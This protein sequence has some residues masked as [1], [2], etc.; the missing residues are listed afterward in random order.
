MTASTISAIFFDLG[1]TLGTPVL[2]PPPSRLVRF[3]VF[4]FVP[5]I[6]D[7]LKRRKFRLGVISNT[8]DD[9][10][11]S[12]NGVLER[13]GLLGSFDPPL[14]IYSKDV[15]LTKSS[16]EI[17]RLAAERAG[18]AGTPRN[19]LFVGEDAKERA[20]A[21]DAGWT[22]APHP[23]LVS[24]AL[25]GQ[26]LRYIRA[27]VP[28]EHIG[29]NW[30]EA[31]RALPL[32]PLH[33]TGPQG[34]TV[35]AITSLRIVARLMNM[36]FDLELL[37]SHDAPLRTDLYILRDDAAAGS[38]FL[39][40]EG[41]STRFFTKADDAR[42][43]LRSG[44]E[45]LVVALPA[46]RSLEE[47]HFDRAYHGHTL[48]L[49]PDPSLLDPL[50]G[51][52]PQRAPAWLRSPPARFAG[53]ELSAEEEAALAQ[54]SGPV[55]LDRAE[56]YG[57]KRPL[58]A[59]ST[60]AIASRHI[61][62][63]D[64]K[65]ATVAVAEEFQRIGQGKL[66]VSLHQFTQA[67]RQLQNVEA[68]L[69]GGSP[70]L[71]LVTAHLDSTAAFSNP[72][73]ATHD[74]APGIDDDASGMAAVLSIAEMF[75]GLSSS[76]PPARTI[77]FVL[78]NAEE[79]GLV[80]SKAYA[81]QQRLM[82]APIVAVFQ[83][84]M[85]GYNKELPRTWEIHAGFSSSGDVEQRSRKLAELLGQLSSRVA[86]RLDAPQ[87]YTSASLEGDPAEG[88]SDHASFQAVGY[89]ACVASEDFFVGPRSDSPAPEA[90]PNY[91]MKEDAFIDGDF[92]ADIARVL[93]AGAW[94]TAKSSVAPHAGVQ[95]LSARG[96]LPMSR[97][98]D[99]RRTDAKLFGKTL[100]KGSG[101]TDV[102]A[103]RAETA[104]RTNAIT[105]AP[106]TVRATSDGGAPDASLVGRALTF[107]QQHRSAMGFDAATPADFVPDPTIQRTSAGAAA[108][109][110]QQSYRG[111]TVFQMAR[112]V[113][114]APSGEPVEAVGD[115]VAMQIDIDTEPKLDVLQAVVKAAEHL[116]STAG[117][118]Q[119]DRFGGTYKTP[120]VNVQGFKPSIVAGFPLPSRATV[121]T[122][123]PFEN[124]IPAYLLVF[125]HP[126]GPRLGW[127]VTLTLPNYEDQ[128][129]VI[130][131]ADR[132]QGEVLYSKSTMTGALARGSVY[133]QNPAD[134]PRRMI[135]FPRPISDYPVMP[136]SPLVGFPSDWIAQ[137]EAMG[138]STRAT[139]GSSTTT[140]KGTMNGGV[141]EFNPT[142][143]T[144][145]DQKILNIFFFCNYMHD[146]LYILGFDEAT[147]NF[148]DMNFT[149]T[150]LGGDPVR[151]RAHSGAV[152]GVANMSTPVDGLPPIMNMGLFNGRHTAFDAD[153]VFHEYAHGLTNRLVG[154]RMNVHALDA[155]QSSGMG[156]GWGDYFAL[157]LQNYFRMPQPEKVVTG[158]WVA[159]N[160]GGIRSAPYDDNFPLKY[161]NIV[162]M[163]DEHDIG[164][165][166]CAMLMQMTRNIRKA[167]NS[168]Q[169]G[170][171]L[172]WQIV[173]DSLKLMN[174]NP[175]F[176]DARDAMLRAVDDL[177]TAGRLPPA[178]HAAIVQ[179]C[180]RAFARYG[181]GFRASSAGPNLDG[182]IADESMP[183]E[184]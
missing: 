79:Q 151:A 152:N 137:D 4:P 155:P 69:A 102:S 170:Y 141:I 35:Y 103:S 179:A 25:D 115:N 5:P 44:S 96:G 34:A 139:L 78:F 175:S 119:K 77:R 182:I 138:N 58:S 64:N 74:P 46:E 17:F 153:V 127:H 15:G 21:L 43:L 13:A 40:A 97:E 157:T 86:L 118:E 70:E 61:L 60:D 166:W 117:E 52:D 7:D 106:T 84:D 161:G 63:D 169:D 72:Y 56:R 45:G 183:P 130:V 163:T 85:I 177:R 59:A 39:S 129:V 81:R 80:G 89:A 134:T 53:P 93:A 31:L 87:I 55:M 104:P 33:V 10:G 19:C 14:L 178:S 30:R 62:H 71:V 47:F 181:M 111:L 124:P 68:E 174:A 149:A 36:R 123:G 144:G 24:E 101:T 154:G 128:Y 50:R 165:V 132:G 92:A 6:L 12:V 180:W 57:G 22:V 122:Q 49:L 48:K 131:A 67:G 42:M 41:E 90:N 16:P 3:D 145:D 75:I 100:A 51:D 54:I 146:F 11:A 9:S 66:A 160:P 136:S 167:L 110:L 91:H 147:G 116:A 83:M 176:L 159:Q 168:D 113:R 18:M 120:G 95:S 121:V 133:E 164:E 114:F 94:L 73:D 88:R 184:M 171:R 172:G 142:D 2:S 158:A 65:R 20:T 109:H 29:S 32:V 26:S 82:N 28:A 99:S 125:Y 8:G 98:L 143:G 1:D 150:G 105:A 140:L 112:T 173:V 156:E 126:A 108:V 38:G 135:D 76:A 37:G 107:V 148:Q 27:T 23:Q 162:N